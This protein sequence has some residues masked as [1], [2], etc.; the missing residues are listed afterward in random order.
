[1]CSLMCSL[2]CSSWPVRQTP[3]SFAT[4]SCVLWMY[5]VVTWSALWQIKIRE[6]MWQKTLQQSDAATESQM[7]LTVN[8]AQRHSLQYPVACDNDVWLHVKNP[9]CPDR[10]QC[11]IYDYI[12]FQECSTQW[13]YNAVLIRWILRWVSEVA[14][15]EM[16]SVCLLFRVAVVGVENC[17]CSCIVFLKTV[18]VFHFHS[19]LDY[20]V[21]APLRRRRGKRR[22]RRRCRG[23]TGSIAVAGREK[24]RGEAAVMFSCVFVL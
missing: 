22:G 20:S 12:Y 8:I 16:Q 5:P 18:S 11:R 21:S 6:S 4:V 17:C 15:G 7:H 14:S 10:Q 19:L 13:T 2:M 9:H 23:G 24:E 1:M 3:P